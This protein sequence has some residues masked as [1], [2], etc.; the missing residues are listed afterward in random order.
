MKILIKSYY[1]TYSAIQK[2]HLESHCSTYY[3]FLFRDIFRQLGHTCD[4]IGEKQEGTEIITNHQGYD[5]II[6]WGLESFTFDLNYSTKLLQEFNGKK[7]LYITAQVEKEIFKYFNYI[8]PTELKCYVPFY[9]S[10]YSNS[11]VVSVPFASPMFDFIDKE[12]DNPF[13]DD[14]KKVIYTGI[15]TGRGLKVLNYLA[16]HQINLYVGGIYAPPDEKSCRG[17]TEQEIKTIFNPNIHFL[18]PTVNFPYGTHFKYLKN[19]TLGLNFYPSTG[20]KSKPINSKIIDYLVCGLPIISENESPNSYYINDL[21]AGL[22]TKW[23]DLSQILDTV[24]MALEINWDKPTIQNK[25]REIFNP[26]NVGK[27]ILEVI[28]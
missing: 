21:K 2:G 8:F 28:R 27:K 11:K 23:N 15:I 22:I 4:F 10:R 12:E 16:E 7:I 19:A 26:L 14:T 25:A 9:Q 3:T 17:F 5:A 13:L 6:F 1:G 18:T 24:K 20:M